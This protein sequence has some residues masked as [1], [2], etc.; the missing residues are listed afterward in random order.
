[1][2]SVLFTYFDHCAVRQPL[3]PDY[4]WLAGEYTPVDVDVVSE[5]Q[6]AKKAGHLRPFAIVDRDGGGL[7]RGTEVV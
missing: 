4:I 3:E 2:R 5:K 1:V 7:G 6:F